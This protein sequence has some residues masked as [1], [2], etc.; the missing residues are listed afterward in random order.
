[1]GDSRA[2]SQPG[3]AVVTVTVAGAVAV[4]RSACGFSIG[5]KDCKGL[6]HDVIDWGRKFPL[7]PERALLERHRPHVCSRDIRRL[8]VLTG[9]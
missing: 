1:M 4:E 3:A 9:G 2:G 5:S 6:G 8:N 7:F